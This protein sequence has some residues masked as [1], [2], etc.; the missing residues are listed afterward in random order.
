MAYKYGGASLK[1][2][3]NCSAITNDE[4]VGCMVPKNTNST[5]CMYLGCCWKGT[6]T[7]ATEKCFTKEGGACFEYKGKVCRDS[8]A[9]LADYRDAKRFFDNSFGQSGTEQFLVKVI[10]MINDYADD[11][12]KCRNI[13]VNMLCH[14]TIPPCYSDGTILDYCKEDC[15]KI[16]NECRETIHQVIGGV[17]L[18]MRNEGIDFIHRGIPDCSKHHPRSYY[19]SLPGNKTCMKS[20][21][22]KYE[23][24]GTLKPKV[25]TKKKNQ[26]RD[27]DKLLITLPTVTVSLLILVVCVIILLLWRR[28]QVDIEA[29][30]EPPAFSMRDKLRT[31]S[32]KSF[33]TLLLRNFD[34]N[35][36]RQYRLDRVHYVKELGVGSFGKVFQGRAA[37]LIDK[38]PKKEILVA[39]KALKDDPSKEQKDEF[40]R[41]V[42]LMSILTHPNIVQLLAVSTEEEPYGMIFEFMSGGDLNQYLR[43]AFPA[44]DIPDESQE[45]NKVYLIHEDL[46]LISTQI[47][48]GMQYLAEMKFIHRDLAARNCLVGDSLVV[49]IGDFGMS[50][51]IY[52]SDYYKLS[53]ETALPIR[54]LAPEALKYGKFSL[55]SD[56]YAYGVLLWEIFTFALQPYYGYSNQEVMS[57]IQK[58]IHMG[59][60]QNCPDFV[61]AIMKDCWHEDPAKRLEFSEIQRRL[62]DPFI[63]NHESSLVSNSQL[64]PENMGAP[65][66]EA[67]NKNYDVPRSHTIC[68]RQSPRVHGSRENYDVPRSTTMK[69]EVEMSDTD[70]SLNEDDEIP[71]DFEI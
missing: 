52:T 51:D 35:R 55:K 19:E 23:E 6:E 63:S 34:P 50:R 70:G 59:K 44:A 18:H 53:K 47:A 10:G 11:N 61:Y 65:P 32:L 49:K 38:K 39:V 37:G 29:L 9:T 54:W 12:E 22:F 71:S 48:A 57:F 30:A 56:V 42:T 26:D 33:D 21:F 24:K 68:G 7:N 46:L 16:F 62:S 41:E 14:Y 60:P 66:S 43:N 13:M 5:T 31:E 58:G 69:V 36:L 17:K 40:F 3:W 15:E 2:R 27:D 67:V 28:R 4:K 25:E 64:L 45:P 8:F 1:P 20:G